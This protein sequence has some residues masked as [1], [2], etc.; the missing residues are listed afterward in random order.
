MKHILASLAVLPMACGVDPIE[1]VSSKQSASLATPLR[2]QMLGASMVTGDFDGDGFEDLAV[3]APGYWYDENVGRVYLYRGSIFGLVPWRVIEEVDVNPNA[4]RSDEFGFALAVADF[5]GDHKDDLVI[6]APAAMAPMGTKHGGVVYVLFGTAFGPDTFTRAELDQTTLTGSVSEDGD[7]FGAAVAVGD[8]DGDGHPDLAV[9][10]PG[11]I[12]GSGTSRLQTGFVNTFLSRGTTFVNKHGIAMP[13]ADRAWGSNFGAVLAI[14]DF[15]RDGF[16]DVVVR[17]DPQSDSFSNTYLYQGTSTG[18][19]A[20]LVVLY[21]QFSAIERGSLTIGNF[22]GA[23]YAG[24]SKKK[25]E[26]AV[27]EPGSA[28]LH[29]FRP[30]VHASG[31]AMVEIQTIHTDQL[32]AL[33]TGDIEG[34]G[35]GESMVARD[36]DGDGFADLV[37]GC[38]LATLVLQPRQAGAIVVFRGGANGLSF[39]QAIDWLLWVGSTT[40]YFVAMDNLGASVAVGD[41]FGVGLR[42]I[43]GGLPNLFDPYPADGAF[44]VFTDHSRN[45]FGMTDLFD[46]YRD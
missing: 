25:P 4:A 43:V 28:A 41:F 17:T 11:E 40:T 14:A 15:D 16:G 6:G 45:D 22:D 26:L 10:V 8:L 27:G 21:E 12:T 42:Q 29:V 7:R 39:G 35:C 46:Q 3:G 31:L 2:G 5:N 44:G 38:P 30:D 24:T 18:Y 1:P 32:A 37:V 9:G 36:L 20:P 34:G 13:A 33:A 19:D 23:T